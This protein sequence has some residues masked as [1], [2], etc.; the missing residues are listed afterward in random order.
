MSDLANFVPLLLAVLLPLIAIAL[1]LSI[2]RKVTVIER[3]TRDGSRAPARSSG[4]RRSET[5]LGSM[6]G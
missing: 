3:R 5:E 1:L 2:W 4:S 6:G